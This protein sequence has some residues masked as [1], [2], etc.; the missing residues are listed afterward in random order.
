MRDEAAILYD[1]EMKL[2]EEEEEEQR[3]RDAMRRRCRYAVMKFIA[4]RY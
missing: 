3:E 4:R 1:D 2:E